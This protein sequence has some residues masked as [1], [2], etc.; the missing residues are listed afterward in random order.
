MGMCVAGSSPSIGAAASETS[1][2]EVLEQVRERRRLR[3]AG[4]TSQGAFLLG[5]GSLIEPGR[6]GFTRD[7]RVAPN[8][9]FGVWATGYLAY[10]EHENLGPT[11]PVNPTRK[12]NTAG[13]LV[14]ADLTYRAGGDPQH[15]AQWGLFAGYN[16][17]ESKFT[18]TS[19][20]PNAVKPTQR[21]T[22]P[23]VGSY[24][25]YFNRGFSADVTFKADIFELDPG[26]ATA[27][28]IGM[29]MLSD[30]ATS[31]DL[32]TYTVAAN[33]NQRFFVGRQTWLEPTA[34]V[35]YV[36]TDYGQGATDFSLADGEVWRVQGGV[37]VGGYTP[38]D[39]GTLTTTLTGL[40]YSDVSISGFVLND[41][42]V[43]PNFSPVDEG[44]LRAAAILK[45]QIDRGN[46]A[47]AFV[48]VGAHGGEDV[49]GVGGRIGARYQ[50]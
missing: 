35:R 5:A 29:V 28:M 1:T 33:V 26:Y 20:D 7:A 8:T 4:Q 36:R 21:L 27:D 37:R 31:V 23:M 9:V 40:L 41:N 16:S 19:A 47:S 15:G 13:A 44:K 6:M 42:S 46:G 50:W 38:V 11:E 49:W 2:A 18:F 43:S 25:S 48:E 32:V 22:G 30:V 12:S 24:V 10:E 39:N 34:G 14:G 45:A 3:L 17:T